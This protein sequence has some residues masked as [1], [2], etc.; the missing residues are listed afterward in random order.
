MSKE[1]SPPNDYQ[2]LR[3]TR[4]H[5]YTEDFRRLRSEVDKHYDTTTRAAKR[6]RPTEET[7]AGSS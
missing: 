1:V 6:L 5:S 2:R 4:I 7:A 3:S